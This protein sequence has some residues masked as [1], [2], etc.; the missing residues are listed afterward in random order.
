MPVMWHYGVSLRNIRWRL[1]TCRWGWRII[2]PKL[3]FGQSIDLCYTKKICF[4]V[5]EWHI[6]KSV[7]LSLSDTYLNI[8]LECSESQVWR[9]IWILSGPSLSGFIALAIVFVLPLKNETEEK[10]TCYHY[11]GNKWNARRAKCCQIKK[12]KKKATQHNL[13]NC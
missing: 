7:F 3:F 11:N 1:S 10:N 12:V 9:Y 8:H 4:L 6:L 2:P 5:F 13:F